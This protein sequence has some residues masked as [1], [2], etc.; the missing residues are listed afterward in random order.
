[1][2]RRE[3]FPIVRRMLDPRSLSYLSM[4]DVANVVYLT[5]VCGSFLRTRAGPCSRGGAGGGFSGEDG[6]QAGFNFIW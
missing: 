2:N 5:L 4:Y 6:E 1:M 3:Q